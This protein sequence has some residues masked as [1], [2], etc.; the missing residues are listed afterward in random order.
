MTHPTGREEN[1]PAHQWTCDKCN[2]V[3]A[4]DSVVLLSKKRCNHILRKHADLKTG[5]HFKFSMIKPD[6]DLVVKDVPLHLR[7]WS[8]SYCGLG[9]ENKHAPITRYNVAKKHIKK[10]GGRSAT[11]KKNLKRLSAQGCTL[12]RLGITHNIARAA[13]RLVLSFC[14]RW[15]GIDVVHQSGIGSAAKSRAGI[16][17]GKSFCKKFSVKLLK[18]GSS[19]P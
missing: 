11:M 4:S 2:V 6:V 10:C 1:V 19:G 13:R 14:S 15:R 17:W 8:C 5:E 16:T 7:A 18:S 9:L 12:S 3:I